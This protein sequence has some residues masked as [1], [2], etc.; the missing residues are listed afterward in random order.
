MSACTATIQNDISDQ[1][2]FDTWVA[3]INARL[4]AIGNSV[5]PT[6]AMLDEI[7]N[8]IMPSIAAHSSCI[9]SQETD[10]GSLTNDITQITAANEIL[11]STIKQRKNDVAIAHDRAVISRNPALTRSYYDSWLPIGRPLKHYTIPLLIGIGLFFFS[12][13]FFYLLNLFGLETQI[14][15]KIPRLREPGTTWSYGVLSLFKATPFRV[16]AVLSAILLG[17]TVYGFAKK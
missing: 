10:A 12:L 15:V 8:T 2:S 13:S 11:N 17:T 9:L 3:S 16:M 14:G 1:P 4:T 7:N 5:T 6:A